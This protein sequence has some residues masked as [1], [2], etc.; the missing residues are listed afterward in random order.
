MNG[1]PFEVTGGGLVAVQPQHA[2]A[3]C[4]EPDVVKLSTTA[5]GVHVLQDTTTQ[6]AAIR[7][8]TAADAEAQSAASVYESRCVFQRW[9]VR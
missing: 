4:D 3:I 7:L 1:V 8:T 6:R 9:T 2:V 5:A